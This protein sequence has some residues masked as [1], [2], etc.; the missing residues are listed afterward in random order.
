[1]LICPFFFAILLFV[2]RDKVGDVYYVCVVISFICVC[3]VKSALLLSSDPVW[4]TEEEQVES[5]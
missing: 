3:L 5:Q 2:L 4:Q 1:M